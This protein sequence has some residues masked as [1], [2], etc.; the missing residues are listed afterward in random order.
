VT[1][2][3]ATPSASFHASI[4][5]DVTVRVNFASAQNSRPV[6]RALSVCNDGAEALRNLRLTMTPQPAFCR[7]KSWALQDI[8][9]GGEVTITDLDVTLDLSFL[10]GLD[11]AERGSLDFRLLSDEEEIAETAAPIEAL[12]RDE[13]GGVG[14]MA[15]ILAAF[16][17]PNDPAI[18]TLLKEASRLLEQRGLAGDLDGYQRQDPRRVYMLAA[19]IWS[20]STSLNLTYAEPPKSFEREGQKVRDPGRVLGEGLATCLDSSLLLCAAL[21]AAGFNPVVI[22][23]Q[24]HAFAGVWLRPVGFRA[25]VEVDVTEVRKAIAS[26][27]LVVF[28]TTLLC[29]RPVVD[30]AAAVAQGARQLSEAK[31]HLFDRAVDISRCRAAGIR[32]LASRREGAV[33]DEV[34]ETVDA[35]PLPPMPDFDM[36]PDEMVEEAPT[37]AT[38][39][40]ERWQRKLLDLS[41]RNR[42]LN[43]ADTKQ[44][45]PLL[46]PDVSRVEDMLADGT[47]FKLISLVDE[48]PVGDRSAALHAQRTGADIERDF[49][50]NALATRRLVATLTGKDLNARL[51]TL[52][53]KAKSDLQEGGANTLF[54]AVGFLRW[55]KSP[56]DARSYSAPLLLLPIRL[57]RRSAGAD[58][59]LSHHE[60]EV[61]FN[62]TLLQFLQRDHG[63]QIAG[64]DG[65][66]PRDASGIDVPRIFAMI[67]A[68]VRDAPG[69]EVVE[70]TAISTFSFA[71][72]LMWKDLV[73]RTDDL[74]RNRL[75]QHL[76][77]SPDQPFS[78]GG[79]AG[80]PQ[81]RDIDRHIRPRDLLT[82]LPADSS[83]LAAVVAA[84]QGHDFVIIGPPG[85][86]K[87][88]TIANMIAHCLAHGKTVLFVAEKSAALDVVYR[89]LKH[90]GLG[91]ACLE[92][93]SS[94]SDR[95]SVI[96]QLGVSWARAA[97]EAER[98]WIKVTGDLEVSR[99]RLNAY[100]EALHAPGSHGRSV[101]EA[102]T[103]AAAR[104]APFKLKFA[105]VAA[106]DRASFDALAQLS[107]D[108]GLAWAAARDGDALG[109]VVAAEWSFGWQEDL[110]TRADAASIAT[111]GAVAAA[112]AL[113]EALGLPVDADGS[114]ARIA[115]LS[116]YA[117]AAKRAGAQDFRAAI[118]PEFDRFAGAMAALETAIGNA[119]QARAELSARYDDD[120]VG[121]IPLDDLDRDWREA[122]AKFWPLSWLAKRRVTK[123]LQSY[124]SG[125]EADPAQDIAPLRRI[126]GELA[127]VA[128]SPLAVT[129]AFAGQNT[130]TAR[131]SQWLSDADALRG[132]VGAVR[133]AA[134]NAD[135]VGAAIE[136]LLS[137][138]MADAE[139][140]RIAAA[141][142]MAQSDQI[143]ALT[144]Y[145][146]HAGGAPE[147]AS[148]VALGHALDA[149][150]AQKARLADRVRWVSLRTMGAARGLLPLIEALEAGTLAP[151]AAED[152]FLAAYFA[153]WTP[154]AMDEAP[155]LRG[156]LAWEHEDQ[157][158]T[159]RR[160]DAEAQGL[161]AAQVRRRLSHDLPKQDAV[162]RKSE[163]GTLRHQL[164]LQR[165]SMPI[166]TLIAKMPT[167]FTK[168]APCV[169]MSPL[170]VA[171]YLPADHQGFD[172]VIF[173]EASQITTW[174]AVG[175]IARGRQ[176][177]IVGDPKQLPPTN[178]FGRAQSDEEGV[179]EFEKDLPSILDEASAAGLP[180]H[181]LNWHYRS[182]D[183]SLIAFSNSNYYGGR[184]VTFP[185]PT[186]SSSAV[187]LHRIKGEFGRGKGRT[188][189]PEAERIVE[190]A[191]SR[192]TEWLM[193]PEAERKTLGVITFNVQQQELILDLLD[194][195]RRK[196]P[197]L[198]WFF[199]DDR[200]EPVI[201]KNLE[202]I[203]GDERDVMLFSITFGPDA[204]G[205]MTMN[206][207]AL[208]RDGGEK[209]L[210]VAVTRA[211]EELHVF[212]SIDAHD[213]D[214]TR[215]KAT[216]VAHL[217]QFLDFAARGPVALAAVD[218][219]SLGPAE[220]PFE[221][222]IADALR[223]KGWEVRTQIG[224]SGFRIDLGVVH[225]DRAG[226]FLAGVECDGATYHSSA[227]ARDRDQIRENV[228][229]GLG[230]TVLR[231]WST[232]W[233]RSKDEALARVHK[234]LT[235]ALETSRAV[236]EPEEEPEAEPVLEGGD[237][238]DVAAPE[239]AVV[240]VLRI[241]ASA[242]TLAPVEGFADAAVPLVTEAV[243]E[244]EEFLVRKLLGE[245]APSPAQAADATPEAPA[246]VSVSAIRQKVAST[247]ASGAPDPERFQEPSYTPVL[248]RLIEEIVAE[249]G[250][251]HIDRL[252]RAIARLHGWQRTGE[253]IRTRVLK[254]VPRD[255][256]TT[257][258]HGKFVWGEGQISEEIPFRSWLD[259]PVKERP[260]AEIIGA[261]R[262]KRAQLIAA[263]DP[264]MEL[265]RIIG[266]ARLAVD[267]RSRLDVYIKRE[268]YL[269][270]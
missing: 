126:K 65:E 35:A 9:P 133:Q 59:Q 247:L 44:T 243:D 255:R 40:I 163:L 63:L 114:A 11:E 209:R 147:V 81:P 248:K 108:L 13:W 127:A 27:E 265:A 55:K 32:P 233:F 64:L 155:T 118:S 192:M 117:D 29:R 25:A 164:G 21:E 99:D 200:E 213:I 179:E 177:V 269:D 52:S 221:E 15:Q 214:T 146:A 41:L 93:H 196:E 110:L 98:Q 71:K 230:W 234:A 17:A 180:T 143:A 150:V 245:D 92:L 235:E 154:R 132:A 69:F 219:G 3:N 79:A 232:D 215:T 151:E 37:T 119:R 166:R 36:L 61:R 125:G 135:A 10:G 167:T 129:P 20:A 186:T 47:T 77:D 238:E 231:I 174:D 218:A 207:G 199:E 175:A 252:A 45:I 229:N 90:Y 4:S 217:K 58:H 173:D 162:A 82:P 67:R 70:D 2:A 258:A 16:V 184:L 111:R 178:F 102:I 157:R 182:R 75:V 152:A 239:K 83:Q 141:F 251:I 131:L 46:C 241:A 253:V 38:G 5:A 169:L 1:E 121:R 242:Q 256:I 88:Q 54:L 170:S 74:R 107:C 48:N 257:E 91:D 72:F 267:T 105:G 249:E 76:I 189:R 149:I 28:E 42:L 183:E 148:L 139:P 190:L 97:G 227:T 22:F 124:A 66:L 206:F 33:A 8:A 18:A 138:G 165:P 250:P 266:V 100:V 122:T 120:E 23:T 144:A 228:L 205:K 259:L 246:P 204:A 62:A 226:A 101:F 156:F 94:K 123:L 202:N 56:E 210:N 198:E 104:E 31:E 193:K 60:D 195:A 197:E 194:A 260:G 80:L 130:E 223:G 116:R 12:A 188:N 85:T 128:A 201:V 168:L 212:A 159:F 134:Q 26:H 203:Q 187:R 53:R 49:A 51:I 115:L 14:A 261:I 142:A 160:L 112:N 237:Q 96:A 172:M 225:P 181:Q 262:R 185:A 73:D 161:A 158:E 39:R 86:G 103:V 191:V 68:A 43:F 24:G 87:S 264:T 34:E 263:D 211:R 30:F 7:S 137:P 224:V 268:L 220:N 244:D 236:A 254:C 208:N 106:H 57:T 222:S 140:L 78:A 6:L 84:E 89:R 153:W 171:Q 176:S 145:A 95:K 113:S 240:P 19:A 50:L 270:D 136:A 109:S 216:G